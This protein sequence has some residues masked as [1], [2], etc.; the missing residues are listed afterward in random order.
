[1]KISVRNTGSDHRGAEAAH[2]RLTIEEIPENVIQRVIYRIPN[3]MEECVKHED[4]HP[5]VIFQT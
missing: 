1:M 4:G 3:R 5:I 2:S